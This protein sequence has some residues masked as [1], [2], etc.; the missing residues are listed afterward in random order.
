M[1]KIPNPLE[2]VATGVRVATGVGVDV[3]SQGVAKVFP[4]V[5]DH[6]PETCQTTLAAGGTNLY[7]DADAMLDGK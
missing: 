4:S 7:E 3:A 2:V 6:S 5:G 1:V